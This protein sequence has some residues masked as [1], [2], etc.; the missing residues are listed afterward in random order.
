MNQMNAEHSHIV[1]F[2]NDYQWHA[3]GTSEP[4][5]H[6]TVCRPFSNYYHPGGGW[7][8]VRGKTEISKTVL[9][10]DKISDRFMKERSDGD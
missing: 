2:G 7:N 1:C 8:A 10:M 9:A 3:D 6:I 4:A 5:Y